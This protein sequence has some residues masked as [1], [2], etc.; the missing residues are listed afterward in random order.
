M[1]SHSHCAKPLPGAMQCS[2]LIPRTIPRLYPGCASSGVTRSLS[3]KALAD[4]LRAPQSPRLRHRA[5][6]WICSKANSV[7]RYR[8]YPLHNRRFP[9]SGSVAIAKTAEPPRTQS[10]SPT[11]PDAGQRVAR[12]FK[13]LEC[14]RLP[15]P[16][17]SFSRAIAFADRP[18]RLNLLL[19]QQRR[20]AVWQ[21]DDHM[22]I[23]PRRAWHVNDNRRFRHAARHWPASMAC[24]REHADA[25]VDL[26]VIA[27]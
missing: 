8:T 21:S 7:M 20:G 6:P 22:V 15:A 5:S 25:A 12:R 9:Q 26:F 3:A 19:D 27:H 23:M 2:G 10:P 24:N 1:S 4:E 11:D 16:N 18:C 13:R 17:A 14:L